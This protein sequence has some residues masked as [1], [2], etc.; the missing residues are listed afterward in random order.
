MTKRFLTCKDCEDVQIFDSVEVEK[1]WAVL[2]AEKEKTFAVVQMDEELCAY[3]ADKFGGDD[4]QFVG[5][6]TSAFRLMG[7]DAVV[8][9]SLAQSVCE[10]EGNSALAMQKNAALVKEYYK[11]EG[12]IVRV[13]CLEVGKGE[14][15]QGIDVQLSM[16]ELAE[17]LDAVESVG[18]S[19]RAL[20]ESAFDTPFGETN[21]Q[22][23]AAFALAWSAWL[24]KNP[25]GLMETNE[26]IE[27]VVLHDDLT[28]SKADVQQIEQEIPKIEEIAQKE[29]Q[30]VE[31]TIEVE[32][33]ENEVEEIENVEESEKVIE[34][35]ETVS[36]RAPE[37]ETSVETKEKKD[38]YYT[39]MSQRDRRKMKRSKK[40]K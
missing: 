1:A 35:V 3:L 19:V 33:I 25:S 38:P 31:N 12:K 28:E 7:A 36:E 15:I 27:T 34:E 32:E 24:E 17:M 23:E 6:I 39:R 2:F 13:I 40:G 26:E 8:E 10:K 9:T 18:T 22:N 16:A 5:K 4:K 14:P 20:Q 29:I 11:T 21:E 37:E 30:S